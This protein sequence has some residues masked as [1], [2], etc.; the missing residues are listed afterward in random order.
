MSTTR[1]IET[2]VEFDH[3]A[4]EDGMF[5]VCTSTDGGFGWS[6]LAVPFPTMDAAR[7]VAAAIRV[8][9]LTRFE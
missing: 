8:G 1:Q 9:V 4:G 6:R 7:R 2:R 5:F 3:F